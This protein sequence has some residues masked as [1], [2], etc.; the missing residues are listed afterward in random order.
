MVCTISVMA[1]Y[2]L[3]EEP[4]NELLSP[5]LT[6]GEWNACHFSSRLDASLK[7]SITYVYKVTCDDKLVLY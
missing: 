2:I 4:G 3:T 5:F 7:M 6:S 1:A